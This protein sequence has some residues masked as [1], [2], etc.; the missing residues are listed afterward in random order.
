MDL[1]NFSEIWDEE[2]NRRKQFRKKLG[3][4]KGYTN[5]KCVNCG[6]YRVE[7]Y[8]SGSKVCEKCG[9]DQRTK[10]PYENEYGTFIEYRINI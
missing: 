10:R 1:N 6:R 9:I 7:L 2:A 8:S 4:Y 5:K 3:A